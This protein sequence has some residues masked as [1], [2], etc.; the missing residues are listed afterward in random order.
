PGFELEAH[1]FSGRIRIDFPIRSEGP[2]RVVS[3]GPRAVRGR[4]GDASS[5]LRLQT[6][7]G[8]VTVTRQ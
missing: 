7:S 4:Y 2:I 1:T 3:R 8:S 6:F 5:S